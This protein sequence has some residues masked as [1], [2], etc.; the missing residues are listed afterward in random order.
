MDGEGLRSDITVVVI[1]RD[2][3]KDMVRKSREELQMKLSQL[4][5]SDYHD[6]AQELLTSW[7]KTLSGV[8]T[9]RAYAESLA[10]SDAPEDFQ[11]VCGWSGS[12]DRIH[13]THLRR[14]VESK[15]ADNPPKHIAKSAA[16]T[17]AKKALTDSLPLGSYIG[18]L[19]LYPGK[20]KT[21]SFV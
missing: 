16:K 2:G 13:I 6:A 8:P 15:Y 12:P 20:F 21:V 18:R 1:G 19:N 10:F 3:Y 17:V 7:D 9:T 5:A 4:T 11:Y 14:V